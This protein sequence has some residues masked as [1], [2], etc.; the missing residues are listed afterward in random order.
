[1]RAIGVVVSVDC[2]TVGVG[3]NVAEEEEEEEEEVAEEEE[4]ERSDSLALM[5]DFFR[6]D[7]DRGNF[8]A[9]AGEWSPSGGRTKERQIQW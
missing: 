1:V 5:A 9:E 3:V 2:R 4:G 7:A 8:A 6:L